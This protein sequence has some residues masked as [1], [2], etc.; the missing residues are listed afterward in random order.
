M[1]ETR[2]KLKETL[3][4]TPTKQDYAYADSQHIIDFAWRLHALVQNKSDTL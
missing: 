4:N 2:R 3:P 1:K